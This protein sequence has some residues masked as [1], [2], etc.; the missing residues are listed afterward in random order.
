M[1]LIN[2]KTLQLRQFL[3]N[4]PGYAILSHTWDRDADEVTLQE[5]R[6]RKR[7]TRAK[8]GYKKIECA[9]ERAAKDGYEWLWVDTCCI[10]KRSSAELSE[11]INSMFRYYKLSEIC[12]ALLS[13]VSIGQ[14]VDAAD[15]DFRKSRWFTRGWTLQELIAPWDIVFFS[16][17]WVPVGRR[18]DMAILLE[19]ITGIDRYALS[20]HELEELSV[21]KRMSW[22]SKR[23]TTRPE[24]MAYCLFGLFDINL[25]PL[26]GEGSRAFRRLQEE[27]I[28]QADDHSIFAWTEERHGVLGHLDILAPTPYHFLGA[29]NIVAEIFDH[30]D[31]TSSDEGDE[32]EREEHESLP[33][34]ITNAGVQIKL[35]LRPVD[36][37]KDKYE[38]ALECTM[39][40][41]PCDCN[42]VVGSDDGTHE[43]HCRSLLANNRVILEL[44]KIKAAKSTFSR[45]GIRFGPVDER[46]VSSRIY[47]W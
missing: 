21:A 28:K 30:E 17:S 23:T 42:L 24:D 5:F 38:A 27:I 29:G 8:S 7:T 39:S 47:L 35:P 16:S 3:G 45:R 4:E 31:S 41:K 12:Y 34:S 14:K 44:S 43:S 33:F 20:G 15:S 6:K 9:A 10:D 36:G 37:E 18:N 46:F 25:P 11:A 13:D 22:A 40:K 26:Y 19:E 32:S 1:W 2:T